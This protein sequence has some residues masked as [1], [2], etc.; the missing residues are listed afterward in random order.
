MIE[1]DT[2][3]NGL[4]DQ[5]A[6]LVKKEI[7]EG[8]NVSAPL[9]TDPQIQLQNTVLTQE[10]KTGVVVSSQNAGAVKTNDQFFEEH[11]LTLSME[12]EEEQLVNFLYNM[13]NDPAM[14]RVARLDLQPLDANRY[15]LRGKLTLTASYTKQTPAAAKPAAIKPGGP[16]ASSAK[17]PP[18][19]RPPANTAGGKPA[20]HP[21]SGPPSPIQA[22]RHQPGGPPGVQPPGFKQGT[23]ALPG[24][25]SA[26][27][28]QYCSRLNFVQ[29]YEP[30]KF[31]AAFS[32]VVRAGR[33]GRPCAGAARSFAPVAA[34]PPFCPASHTFRFH[35]H[36]GG[37]SIGPAQ[38]ERQSEYA[39]HARL[40]NNRPGRS[41]NRWRHDDKFD[42]ADER[43]CRHQL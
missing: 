11:S 5:V 23:S 3:A 40:W 15:K 8:A 32:A 16:K 22:P 36:T 43:S 35:Q 10:R 41:A 4:R 2:R 7:G 18:A 20:P 29:T 31:K 30:K 13:G 12:S 1:E 28:W 19:A 6:K 24:E 37:G 34:R 39:G 14:I 42:G 25:A 33:T 21:N 26:A 27:S 17:T 9:V 38:P